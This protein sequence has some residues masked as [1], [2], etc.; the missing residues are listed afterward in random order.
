[1]HIDLKNP[2]LPVALMACLGLALALGL[3]LA[4]GAGVSTDAVN[5]LSAADHLAGGAG[6]TNFEGQPYVLWPPLYP[7]LLAI[8]EAAF[9][10]DA[11]IFGGYLNAVAFAVIIFLTG[12]LA[13]RILDFDRP[14]TAF[15]AAACLLSPGTFAICVNI[16]SDAI[17]IVLILA[18]LLAFESYSCGRA[19]RPLVWMTVLCG[20]A[21]LQRYIGATLILTGF[22]GIVYVHRG[23]LRR[24]LAEGFAFAALSALPL[25]LY[26]ARNYQVS[27]TLI[28]VRN[29]STW[30]PDQN[31][32]DILFKASRWFVPYQLS[33]QPLF[34]LALILGVLALLTIALRRHRP[35][36][37]AGAPRSTVLVLALFSIVYLAA[38]IVLTKSVDHMN[39]LYDDRLYL[40]AF[41]SLFLLGLLFV[42]RVVLPAFRGRFA[43]VALSLAALV[44]LAF[45]A[46]GLYKFW[47]RCLDIGGIAYY[48]IYNLPVYRD[49][50][51]TRQLS[52]WV[53]DPTTTV[54]SDYPAAVYLFARRDV[55]SLPSRTDFFGTA[56]PLEDFAGV[57][58]GASSAVLVWYEPNTKRNL[59]GLTELEQLARLEPEFTSDDGAIYRVLSK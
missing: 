54:F 38:V 49:S 44:W 33:S 2:V 58:P 46:N 51:V 6:L 10:L 42:R 15:A 11:V 40:P 7:I 27:G 8:P 19:R 26:T 29:P 50:Q 13:G 4:H 16:G 37:A 14:L 23:E 17:F 24:G 31:L 1:M 39:I 55:L 45:P 59:Y 18:F 30:R 56:T 9:R 28:G 47:A 53:T 36:L 32:R 20:L 48:N 35:S 5:Y 22:V 3:T 52:T 43:A 25:L 41:F 21:C 34:W 12:V 57:W